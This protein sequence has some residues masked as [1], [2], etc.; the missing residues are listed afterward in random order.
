[1]TIGKPPN[2]SLIDA[3]SYALAGLRALLP[4]RAFRLEAVLFFF[5][6]GVALITQDRGLLP[7]ISLCAVL[8]AV[9][10]LNTAIEILC[11]HVTPEHHPQIKAIKD[12]AAAASLIILLMV[13]VNGGF[14]LADLWRRHLQ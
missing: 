7:I 13:V 11:D 9:E 2:R 12:I 10:A 3:A 5:W 1:M 14:Y 4:H 8:L 6:V